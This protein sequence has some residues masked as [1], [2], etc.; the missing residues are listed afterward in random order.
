[1]KYN[2]EIFKHKFIIYNQLL[3]KKLKVLLM[4]GNHPRRKKEENLM[5]RS[6]LNLYCLH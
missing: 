5:K 1:M 6:I 4:K 2:P 3:E